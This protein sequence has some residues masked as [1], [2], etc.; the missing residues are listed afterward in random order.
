MNGQRNEHVFKKSY[1]IGHVSRGE[2]DLKIWHQTDGMAD[3][4]KHPA[5]LQ[6][7]YSVP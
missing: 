6:A 3:S 7:K 1:F 2:K 4:S 5:N